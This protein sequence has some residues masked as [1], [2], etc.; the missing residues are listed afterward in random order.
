MS[1]NEK[2]AA[3]ARSGAESTELTPELLAF[4]ANMLTAEEY[5]EVLYFADRKGKTAKKNADDFE[6]AGFF[7][8]IEVYPMP[9]NGL[10]L[11]T[12]LQQMIQYPQEAIEESLEGV[13]KIL[14]MVETD[15]SVSS[16]VILEDIGANCADQVCKA[17]RNVKLLPA[18]QNGEPR[19]CVLLVPVRFELAW[20]N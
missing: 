3:F 2:A 20:R 8:D 4:E 16:V 15:G 1:G 9:E 17:I 19:R 12:T 18:M 10:D 14:C 7:R 5:A 6:N 13:V 11:N